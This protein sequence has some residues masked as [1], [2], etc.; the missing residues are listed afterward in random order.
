MDRKTT[1]IAK[2]Q[3]GF[4]DNLICP[5]F[6]ILTAVLPNVQTNLDLM[7]RNKE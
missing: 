2:A 5:A 4:I 3:G 7:W 1:N 6:Q